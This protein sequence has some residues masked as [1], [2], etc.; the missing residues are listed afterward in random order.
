[1]NAATMRHPVKYP[2]AHPN[3]VDRKRIDRALKARKRYRYVSPK[4]TPVRGGY[5]VESPCCSGSIDKHGGA[6]DVA[7]IHHDAISATWK[8]FRKDHARGTWKFHSVHQRLSAVT[9]ELNSDL[10][11][12]FWR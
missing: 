4:V 6:I 10:D 2:I 3:E 8:L 11:R 7:L 5:L 9:D 12:V 1:M